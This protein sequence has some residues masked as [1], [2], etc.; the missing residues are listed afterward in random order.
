MKDNAKKEIITK[1][2]NLKEKRKAVILV[3][4]YQLPEVQDIA[5]FLGDSLDLSRKAAETEAQVIVFCGV[6]FMA[7]TAAIL[8]PEKKVLLPDKDAGCP[9]ANMITVDDLKRKKKEHPKAEVVSYVNTTAE[10]KAESDICCT[11]SNSVKIVNSIDKDKEIIF[12]PDKYLCDYTSKQTGR[13]LLCWDGY[14][15]VHVK[16]QPEH[17][18][19]MKKK[20][21]KAVVLVHPECTPAVIELADVVTSTGGMVK[22]A[23]SSSAKEFIIGTEI[24]IIYRLKRENPDKDF[25]PATEQAIC[26][27]MKLTTLEK[28]LWSLEDLCYEVKILAPIRNKAK[29]ALERMLTAS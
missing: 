23:K 8:S 27:T 7:Q 25:Y 1:I 14:C 20:H 18:Q 16:I 11:S 22:Y 24:G 5:D 15:P 3:H 21:P 28:I 6:D 2:Q 10:V 17:I 4:N 19:T 13:K 9:L 29:K 26:P 12:A